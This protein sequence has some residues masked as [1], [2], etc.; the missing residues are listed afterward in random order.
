LYVLAAARAAT[1][2]AVQERAQTRLVE[3][4]GGL[5]LV[6][7]AHPHPH[8]PRHSHATYAVGLVHEGANRFRYRGAWCTAPAGALCT[9]TPDEVHTVEPA[10]GAGFA[11]R[12]LYPPAALLQ[13]VAEAGRGRRE[14]PTLLL[15]PVIEDPSA[16][17]RARALFA[18]L[19]AGAPPL[20]CQ[21]RLAALLSLLVERHA[22]PAAEERPTRLPHL[23]VARARELLGARLSEN[24]TL[25][26]LSAATGLQRFA[27]LRAFTRAYGLPPH[28]WVI[29]ERV[30]R[31][32]GLL[33]AGLA[34]AAVAANL[35]F[36]DQSHL[37]RHLKRLT[38]LTPG[39][40]WAT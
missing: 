35:G 22:R 34:P 19:E 17:H 28:A 27:L 5:E 1:I 9:V 31:A 26:Q 6:E 4:L 7:A 36:T 25:D 13:E 11:Y 10:G 2:G 33:R 32:Q 30:R 8:F 38:G 24:L 23:A 40:Y 15:P 29:Q 3:E 39:C 20:A 21:G 12:C 18:A 16:A 14:R 37:C